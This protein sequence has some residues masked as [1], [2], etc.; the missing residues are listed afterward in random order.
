MKTYGGVEVL[1]HVFLTSALDGGEWSASRPCRFTPGS[2]WIIGWVGLRVGLDAV[3]KRKSFHC[4]ESNPGRPAC[5]PTPYRL[6]YPDSYDL[7]LLYFHA[8]REINRIIDYCSVKNEL[9]R[10]KRAEMRTM[11]L[12]VYYGPILLKWS[13]F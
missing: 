10:Y 1:I 13:A 4:R 12:N 6:S 9:D 7:I 2:H 3:E 11:F 8:F 5:C